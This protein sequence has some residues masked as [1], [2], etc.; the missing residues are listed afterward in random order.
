MSGNLLIEWCPGRRAPQRWKILYSQFGVRVLL[1]GMLLLETACRIA[2]KWSRQ[3]FLRWV[4]GRGDDEWLWIVPSV[5]KRRS[6]GLPQQLQ[7]NTRLT[8]PPP[9][10]WW[11][12]VHDEAWVRRLLWWWLSWWPWWVPKRYVIICYDMICSVII[13]YVGLG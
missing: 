3:R 8:H 7:Y 10:W 13:W 6:P 4:A 12:W 2:E 5:N 11:W 9:P 1:L